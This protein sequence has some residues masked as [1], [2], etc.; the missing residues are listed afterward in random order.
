M[1]RDSNISWLA[2]QRG[3]RKMTN[4]ECQRLVVDTL[5]DNRRNAEPVNQD[6]P[7]QRRQNRFGLRLI[8]CV[9]VSDGAVES[10]VSVC[11]VHGACRVSISAVSQGEHARNQKARSCEAE[12]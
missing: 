10:P 4:C 5:F 7:Y 11:L 8:E 6:F 12:S 2:R 9:G 3:G 1:S